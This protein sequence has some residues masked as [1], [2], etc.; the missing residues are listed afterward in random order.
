MYKY[1][2]YFVLMLSLSLPAYGL[3]TTT[4]SDGVVASGDREDFDVYEKLLTI[5]S[6]LKTVKQHAIQNRALIIITSI[7]CASAIVISMPVFYFFLRQVKRSQTRV[8][9]FITSSQYSVRPKG[10]EAH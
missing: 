3:N 2:S 1:L 9:N 7:V 4:A 6:D 5:S 10:Q 8:Q